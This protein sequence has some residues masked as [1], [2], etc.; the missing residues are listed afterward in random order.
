M[1]KPLRHVFS[2]EDLFVARYERLF[3]WALRLT[4]R[5]RERAEDLLHDA[6]V[7][8]TL[9]RP[10][11]HEIE[12]LDGYLHRMLRN[13]HLSEVRRASQLQR[14][15]LSILDYDSAELGLRA[16]ELEMQV[17]EDLRRICQYAC[18]RKETSK[19]GSVLILRFF[20]GYYPSEVTLVLRSSK[21]LVGDWLRIARREARAYLDDPGSLKFIAG[22]EVPEVSRFGHKQ[23]MT[24]LLRELR[25]I[26][27]RARR[28]ECL[29]PQQLRE[30][31]RTGDSEA[32]DGALLAHF[33]SCPSC[34]DEVNKLLDLPLLSDRHPM[35]TIGKHTSN[36]EGP[37]GGAAGGG[38]PLADMVVKRCRRRFTEVFEHE[39]KELR[40]S[41]NGFILFSQ[42]VSSETNEQTL[43]INIDEQ[44]GFIE[45]FSE[46]G[47]RLLFF[48]VEQP[49]EGAVEQ[50]AGVEL[51]DARALDL[52]LSFSGLWPTLRVSYHDPT[53]SEVNVADAEEAGQNT[54]DLPTSPPAHSDASHKENVWHR[55]LHFIAR[56]GQRFFDF[57]FWLRPGAITAIFAV[58]LIAALLFVQLQRF[59]P[60]T[61]SAAELLRRT[62]V[63][64][65]AM[66]AR[67]DTVVQRTIDLEER[68]DSGELIARHR[69][70]V[71][72]SAEKGITA[73]RLYN[74]QNQLVAGDWR[75]ADGVQT[76]YRHG[77]HP[78]L[79]LRN[80]QSAIRN[81]E[82]WQLDPSATDF[83]RLIGDATGARVEERPD[84]YVIAYA[85]EA[86][87]ETT[88]LVRATLVLARAD[89]HPV[90][91]TL[92]VR[93]ASE[94]RRYRFTESAFER[95]APESVAPAV[96]EPEPELL[97]ATT[98]RAEPAVK[99]AK[100]EITTPELKPAPPTRPVATAEQ[101]VEVLRL[102]NS[103]G[104][105]LGE[106]VSVTRT[107]D[108]GLKVEG[109]VET[110]ARQAELLR[111]LEPVMN[112]PAMRVEIQTVAEAVAQR[113]LTEA[114]SVPQIRRKVE[115]AS[116]SIAVESELRGYFAREGERVD[117]AVRQY[118]DRM[119]TR[120][121]R[122]MR[123]IYA[124]K[125]LTNQFSAEELRSL[126]PEARDKWLSLVR[127]HARSF[128][129]ETVTLRQEL[130]PVF[131][132]SAPQGGV[133]SE[134]QITNTSGVTSAVER[135]F[136][137]GSA[138]D[139]V[140][141]SAFA[142][143]TEG[144]VTTALK[145]GAFWQSLIAAESLAARIQGAVTSDK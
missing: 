120:S 72:H 38:A 50:R 75:R 55:F 8:F 35:D 56:F 142:T 128:E 61:A 112:H 116:S 64:E 76:L 7:Q 58:A 4:G 62:S 131:F 59:T 18:A 71:W 79:Q 48:D 122:A 39:P 103:V 6:F 81:R 23:S 25:A 47:Q 17:Q 73:R 93:Q 123:H 41:V 143:S 110:D 66:A 86:T 144:A 78:Q 121:E 130:R 95:R 85:G 70:E 2:H 20:H 60:P 21:R 15:P 137:L 74:E 114:T 135:L 10:D 51:S 92:V 113:R 87:G 13:M 77:S 49:T 111:A 88:G 43:S 19:A 30:L 36:R 141:R 133:S 129:R 37:G 29:Q 104:A 105:D 44:I 102:L 97:G 140:I 101:E 42:K 52:T 1:L 16:V 89:L 22:T 34:L 98:G 115:I 12:N 24:D 83:T 63:A 32:A 99:P 40:I 109:I 145:T 26:I 5:D 27:Y 90:E 45:V 108:G 53:F 139:R 117:E 69:V 124:L 107:P 126:S 119:V 136:E 84:A 3:A 33:V 132:P 68:K 96:F 31:Y 54:A 57:R 138:N 94:V 118:A 14:V 9:R 80:P 11:L 100:K 91:Q 82:V 125:R 67:T 134:S 46:Q 106:Q 65:E 127:S 28:G